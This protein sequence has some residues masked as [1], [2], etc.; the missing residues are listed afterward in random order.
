MRPGGWIGCGHL[1]TRATSQASVFLLNGA[2]QTSLWI[3]FIICDVWSPSL[4]G[5]S[6]GF[7]QTWPSCSFFGDFPSTDWRAIA[8]LWQQRFWASTSA[9]QI[10]LWT[11]RL[12]S[13]AG[14]Q[15]RLWCFQS[16]STLMKTERERERE[17]EVLPVWPK[18]HW[19]LQTDKQTKTKSTLHV[20]A[21]SL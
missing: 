13:L 10:L 17:R 9:Y 18:K 12:K 15:Q 19:K 7:V 14:F 2:L 16:L 11:G 5:W 8:N 1:W 6:C 4:R 21:S 3:N 20:G